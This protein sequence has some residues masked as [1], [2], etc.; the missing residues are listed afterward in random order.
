MA[1]S[2]YIL[3]F[4]DD[5]LLLG[6]SLGA[7]NKLLQLLEVFCRNNGLKVNA[8]KSKAMAFGNSSVPGEVLVFGESRIEWVE[9]FSYLGLCI[10]KWVSNARIFQAVSLKAK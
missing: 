8:A 2:L 1:F 9:E 6:R 7:I 4:A 3:L 10:D 5:L